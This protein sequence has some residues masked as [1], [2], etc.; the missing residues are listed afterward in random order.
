MTTLSNNELYIATDIPAFKDIQ[1]IQVRA[2]KE[3]R[4]GKP[5]ENQIGYTYTVILPQHGFEQLDVKID[6]DKRIEVQPG[7]SVAVE[8]VNLRVKPYVK[9]DTSFITFSAKADDIRVAN[10][11]H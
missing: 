9:R 6:G 5:T 3:W 4:D 11:H 1:L 10:A 7:K 8:F 2:R